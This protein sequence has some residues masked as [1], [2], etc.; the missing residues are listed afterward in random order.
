MRI[1]G[2]VLGCVICRCASVW[3]T[4]ISVSPSCSVTSG[5]CGEMTGMGERD[6]MGVTAVGGGGF[7]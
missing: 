5:G 6:F 2:R 3:L 4:I 1:A 7:L